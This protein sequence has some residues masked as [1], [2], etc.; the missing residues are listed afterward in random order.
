MRQAH[1]AGQPAREV[2]VDPAL[3]EEGEEPVGNF[4][5]KI[6]GFLSRSS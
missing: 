6:E 2:L 4:V 5:A 1:R 3:E